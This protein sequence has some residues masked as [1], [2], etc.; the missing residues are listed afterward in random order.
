MSTPSVQTA[1]TLIRQP[2]IPAGGG[3]LRALIQS[4]RTA[5]RYFE[6]GG[7]LGDVMREAALS[8]IFEKM[9]DDSEEPVVLVSI[10]HNPNCW[11]LFGF[12]PRAD[13]LTLVD[14]P[15]SALKSDTWNGVHDPKFRERFGLTDKKEKYPR[16]K[17]PLPYYHPSD[18]DKRV[19][20]SV[21]DRIA[22][23]HSTASM[24][25]G[26]RRTL[27]LE[28]VESVAEVLT[29]RSFQVVFIGNNY[30]INGS[31]TLHR[32]ETPPPSPGAISLID[33]LSVPGTIQLVKQAAVSV[34]CDS[35]I[36]CASVIYGTVA[37]L[38]VADNIW[39]SCRGPESGHGKLHG[40]KSY[41]CRFSTYKAA[42]LERF[43]E[44][45]AQ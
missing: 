27:P 25:A 43:L 35:S 45:T 6:F 26:D 10:S 28:I 5:G 39:R 29:R 21:P 19:L 14:L 4:A 37:F 24:G 8:S 41:S 1:A 9:E 18:A 2:D 7:G 44:G 17:G 31:E 40:P 23:I 13:K 36:A 3:P 34:L 22:I 42:L 16:R 15:W 11:E 20:S 38:L 12:H 32:E 30:N 33:K